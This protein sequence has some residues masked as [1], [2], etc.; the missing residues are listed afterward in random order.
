MKESAL[1]TIT[2][3]VQGVGFRYFVKQKAEMLGVAGIVKNLPHGSVYVEA[4]GEPADMETF[5]AFLKIGPPRAYIT[6]I[7]I[8]NCPAQGFR[9]FFIK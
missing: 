2:G 5:I 6:D 9:G 4:E 8:Q 1:I 7:Q 3:R